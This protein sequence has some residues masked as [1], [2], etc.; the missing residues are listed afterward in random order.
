MTYQLKYVILELYI[1]SPIK[2]KERPGRKRE[3]ERRNEKCM[4]EV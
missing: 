3:R 4:N 1:S 2:D